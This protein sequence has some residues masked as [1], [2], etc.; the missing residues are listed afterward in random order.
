MVAYME[1]SILVDY[2]MVVEYPHLRMVAYSSMAV[3]VPMSDLPSTEDQWQEVKSL[4]KSWD[5]EDAA[6]RDDVMERTLILFWNQ[7]EI[8]WVLILS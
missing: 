8:Q 5:S 6:C 1:Y 4:W 3:E 7:H 2:S